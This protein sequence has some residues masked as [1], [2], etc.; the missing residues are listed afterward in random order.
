MHYSFEK[1]AG[2]LG[3]GV[4]NLIRVPVEADHRIDLG[5]L[6]QAIADCRAR[7][8]LVIAVCG[9]AGTTESGAVDPLREMAGIAHR[10]GIHFHVDAAWGGALMFSGKYRHVLAGIEEADSL[11]LDGHKQMYA[12]LGMG[13]V[14]FRNPYLAKVIEKQA[15][16]IIRSGSFDLGKRS[17]EG[18]RSGTA[19]FLHAALNILGRKGYEFLIDEGIR[20]TLYMSHS[21][22]T[23]PEFE[24]L[25]EPEMNILTYRYLPEPW[26]E[27]AVTGDLSESDH[28][29]I[30]GYNERLQKLQRGTGHTFV[31]R[32]TLSTTRYGK[33]LPIVALRAVIA[34][35]LTTESDIDYVLTHQLQLA[36]TLKS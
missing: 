35:P 31:S 21:I 11:T 14:M 8:Q 6:E 7:G 25:I 20:K 32:T 13:I 33:H 28:Q 36:A 2:L 10:A 16:Y 5:A 23:R 34:N 3:I 27:R 22:R 9:I 17:L 4:S 18:S 26:R 15:R 29:S 24:V 1:A 12:P 19:L 30:N